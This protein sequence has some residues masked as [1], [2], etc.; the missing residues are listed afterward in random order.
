MWRTSVQAC[1]LDGRLSHRMFEFVSVSQIR[2]VLPEEGPTHATDKD[3]FGRVPLPLLIK[4]RLRHASEICSCS[5]RGRSNGR[6]GRLPKRTKWI[7]VELEEEQRRHF[8]RR[9]RARGSTAALGRCLTD[10]QSG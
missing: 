2:M 1:G 3:V 8:G 9:F 4:G 10:E 7:Q 6:A 5:D